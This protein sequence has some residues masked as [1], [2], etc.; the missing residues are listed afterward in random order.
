[1]EKKN[2]NMTAHTYNMRNNR[3]LRLC[4]SCW[5]YVT[6]LLNKDGKNGRGRNGVEWPL[7]TWGR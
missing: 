2:K 5:E 6:S 1:M 3:T 7:H 4:R